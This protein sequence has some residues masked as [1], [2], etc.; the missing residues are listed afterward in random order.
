[1][2]DLEWAKGYTANDV[3]DDAWELVSSHPTYE[4]AKAAWVDLGRVV[5]ADPSLNVWTTH[6]RLVNRTDTDKLITS[7]CHCAGPM[8][9]MDLPSGCAREA[10]VVWVF[11]KGQPWHLVVPVGWASPSLCGVCAREER[12]E[13]HKQGLFYVG[14]EQ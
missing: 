5:L 1:M 14:E 12:R 9:A 3:P 7:T 2:I 6:G 11:R 13:M 10:K 4:E 8:D